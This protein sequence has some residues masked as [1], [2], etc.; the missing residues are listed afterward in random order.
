[1]NIIDIVVKMTK[2]SNIPV[3]IFILK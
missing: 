2:S 3:T 1:M